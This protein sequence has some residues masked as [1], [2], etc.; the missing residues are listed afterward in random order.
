[1]PAYRSFFAEREDEEFTVRVKKGNS[2]NLCGSLN[3]T[4]NPISLEEMDE[5]IAR[6]LAEDDARIAQEDSGLHRSNSCQ[7]Q[8]HPSAGRRRT[9]KRADRRADGD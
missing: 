5:A 6:H 2:M 8:T 7:A 9:C 1:M 4:G 3:W